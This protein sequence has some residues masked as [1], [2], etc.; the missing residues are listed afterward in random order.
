MASD[1]D[2]QDGNKSD[3]PNDEYD[4][5]L[6]RRKGMSGSEFAGIGV[7]FA[8]T[9]VVFAMFL[10]RSNKN[11]RAVSGQP[12]EEFLAERIFEPLYT[13]KRDGN[14]LGLSIAHQAMVQQNGTI[15]VSSTAGAGATLT[16]SFPQVARP[17]IG[18]HRDETES[19]RVL[20]VEDDESVGEGLRILLSDE[21][22]EV[23][24]VER[25]QLA[26]P[27]M[28]TFRPDLV[29]LDVNLPDASGVDI[30]DE[31]RVRQPELPVIFSTGHADA[32]ALQEVHDREVPSIMKPYEIDDLIT[33][34]NSVTS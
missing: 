17:S 23:K 10:V 6:H 28:E 33:L 14:G 34:M 32:R 5:L 4:R 8:V 7:Q 20:I 29:L 19:R 13:T 27:A 26:I 22:F 18:F 30:Y 3:A 15:S 16:L 24:L 11:A 12:L 1:H 25:G 21:G 2:G 31:I 9:I